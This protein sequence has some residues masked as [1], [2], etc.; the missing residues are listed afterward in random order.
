VAALLVLWSAVPAVP[1]STAAGDG[2]LRVR[3]LGCAGFTITSGDTTILHDPYLSRPGRL[4][5]LLWPYEPDG[6]RLAPYLDPNGPSPEIA[7]ADLILIGHSHFDHLGDAPWFAA[8]TGARVAGTRTTVAIAQAYGVPAG[9]LQEVGPGDVLTEGP[10][11]IRVVESRHARVLFGREPF[12]GEL[13]HPPR[14]P[15][16][17]WSFK[18][19]GALGYLVVH[20]PSGRRLF[21]LSS[22]AVHEPALEAVQ[23]E[24]LRVDVLL[25]ATI[26][27]SEALAGQLVAATR[28]RMVVPHHFDDFFLPIE[29]ARA[30]GSDLADLP[31][32]R[33]EVAEAARRANLEVVYRRPE[34]FESI[35]VP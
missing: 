20:R 19:G 13:L 16:R 5:T 30:R 26:G 15:L 22:A 27:R 31:R 12:P 25:P 24:G 4:R 2:T 34:F 7:G 6:E 11:E 17:A 9:R 35:V 10:F 1:P 33:A 28:P 14:A 18:L 3:W 8:R 32:F 29:D 21:V 23:A